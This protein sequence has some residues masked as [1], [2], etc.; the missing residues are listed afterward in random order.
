MK[1]LSSNE[2][3]QLR[4]GDLVMIKGPN[5]TQIP[6]TGVPEE[7]SLLADVYYGFTVKVV[8]VTTGAAAWGYCQAFGMSYID[9][10]WAVLVS[11]KDESTSMV[12][13]I[14]DDGDNEVWVN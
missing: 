8:G 7:D 1:R 4:I 5:P 2:I 13:F 12:I 3:L 11:A 6:Y 10:D 9:G 14:P